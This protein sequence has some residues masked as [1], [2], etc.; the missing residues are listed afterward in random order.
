MKKIKIRGFKRRL[1]LLET[2]RLK[3]LNFCLSEYL[4]NNNY[5]NSDILVHPWCDISIVNS[6]FPEPK[7]KIKQKM[8]EGLLD[9]FENWKNQLEK[10]GKPYYLKI[11]IF[12]PRFSRSQVVCAIGDKIDYYE[13]RFF[14]PPN[15]KILDLSK[16]PKNKINLEKLNWTYY[17]DEDELDESSIGPPENWN[18]FNEYLENKIWY[19]KQLKKA[20]RTSNFIN[21]EG[22]SNEYYSFFKGHLW[23][24]Y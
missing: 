2:W 9:I 18:N 19:Y 15:Q 6:C 23:I 16:Y 17:W 13:N 22:Q 1:K 11:W 21:Q 24:G 7:G 12:E 4:I 3:E 8:L 10:M 14:K 5:R 20:H